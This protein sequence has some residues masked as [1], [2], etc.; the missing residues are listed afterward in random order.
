MAGAITWENIRAPNF[1]G[2]SQDLAGAQQGIAA[3][4]GQLGNLVQNIE[5]TE[6]K[7]RLGKREYGT[8]DFLSKIADTY[9]TPEALAAANVPGGAIDQ[10][11]ASYGANLDPT[12]TRG[13]VDELLTQRYAQ[14]KAAGQYKDEA[15]QR[16]DRPIIGQ[17][18]E[19][20]NS[21]NAEDRAKASELLHSRPDL[22]NY[23]E[24]AKGLGESQYRD[25]QRSFTAAEEKRKD[26]ASKLAERAQSATE[27]NQQG[28]LDVARQNA[29]NTALSVKQAGISLGWQ[30]QDR[31]ADQVL[32]TQVALGKTYG[33][34]ATS[35]D[36][37]KII[38]ATLKDNIPDKTN[39][40]VARQASA[41]VSQIP[42]MTAG[43]AAAALSAVPNTWFAN[44][45]SDNQE[46]VVKLAAALLQDYKESQKS[47]AVADQQAGYRQ[48]ILNAQ[49]QSDEVGA[50]L[51]FGGPPRAGVTV[52]NPVAPP[53]Q[54]VAAPVQAP[55]AVQAQPPAPVLAQQLASIQAAARAPGGPSVVRLP[56]AFGGTSSAGRPIIGDIA[57]DTRF[58]Q[59]AAQSAA[60]EAQARRDLVEADTKA[61][62]AAAE[63]KLRA[64]LKASANFNSADIEN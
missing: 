28:L 31:L 40:E 48:A 46:K 59:F 58:T 20:S 35:E 63:K 49:R 16:L 9:K 12:K 64:A 26:A 3:G 10:L 53:A 39:R 17:I 6:E 42:G 32:K 62:K 45:S 15:Q 41:A 27:R 8:Q 5:A 44:F 33:T 7:N 61:E 50:Q 47:A 2:V 4:F 51:G 14:A 54:A 23:G 18:L 37:V 56:P 52:P 34:P 55:T 1:S 13:A 21:V 43:V 57:G 19:L 29:A 36:G 30:Q 38:A 22:T 24:L 11:K 60:A 25:V